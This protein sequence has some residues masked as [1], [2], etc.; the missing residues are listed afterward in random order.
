MTEKTYKPLLI[1]SIIAA[2]DLEKQRFIGIDG[3]YCT[4]NTKAF[5]VSDAGTEAGQYAPVALFGILLVKTA[6]AIT[7]GSKVASDADGY[8]VTFT[9]GE[10]NGYAL[11]AATG[12]GEIIRI[13]RGI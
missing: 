7:K 4:A 3:N 8:A 11:D 1:D 6:G 10:S 9:T 2:A 13:V 12:A 5:G